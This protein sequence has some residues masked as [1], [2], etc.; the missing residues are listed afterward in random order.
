MITQLEYPFTQTQI[1]RLTAGEMVLLSG[2]VFT[3][4]DR[5]HQYL[6]EGNTTPCSLKNCAIYHC[7]PVVTREKGQWRIHAAGPT[8]SS[9]EEL[10]MP[11]IIR[12]LRPTLIIGK[13]GMG[14]A[15]RQAC[16]KY[17][18]AYLHTVGGAAQY[19]AN[20]IVSV[21]QVYFLKEFGPTEAMWELMV[22]D[23]PALVT[24]DAHGNDLHQKI[25]LASEQQLIE[26][27]T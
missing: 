6:A 18:C 9:R 15:T 20:C 24:M 13:G 26:W 16:T 4:R 14:E 1:R 17:G 21:R 7:G 2:L 5:V 11:A 25:S 8:T 12:R 22:K 19:L 3:G 27:Q 23:F 10:Y